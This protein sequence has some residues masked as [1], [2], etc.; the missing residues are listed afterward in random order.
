VISVPEFGHAGE[1]GPPPHELRCGCACG[2]AGHSPRNSFASRLALRTAV[3]DGAVL[4]LTLLISVIAYSQRPPTVER[5]RAG[6][7]LALFLGAIIAFIV[8]VMPDKKRQPHCTGIDV[9]IIPFDL[10]GGLSMSQNPFAAKVE[11]NRIEHR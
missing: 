10:R 2:A 8:L 5:R 6:V 11:I 3:I 7:L 4:V 9:S 1:T